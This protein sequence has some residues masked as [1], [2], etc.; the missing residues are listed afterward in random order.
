MKERDEMVNLTDALDD[1]LARVAAGESL[2]SSLARYTSCGMAVELTALVQARA[3]LSALDPAP[4]LPT[5]ALAA[6]RRQFFASARAHKRHPTS[7]NPLQ[8]LAV[9]LW[10][11]RPA[12]RPA[13]MT[14]LASA[15]MAFVLV[16]GIAGG[17]LTAAQSSLPDSPLY[18][19]KLAVEDARL[20]L[21]GDPS[22]QAMLSLSF[23]SERAREMERLAV[24]NRP[25]ENRVSQR[26]DNQLE[27]ALDAASRAPEHEM[28][29]LLDKV[30]AM[31]QAQERALAQAR[32]N[33]PREARSQDALREAEQAMAQARRQAHAGLADPGAF[34]NRTRHEQGAP[35]PP[36]P[37]A[38]ATPQPPTPTPAAQLTATTEATG[39]PQ[40]SRTPQASVTPQRNQV[41]TGQ[42]TS[43]PGPQA[44]VTP[45]QIGPGPQPTAGSTGPGPQPTDRPGDGPGGGDGSG[46]GSGGGTGGTRRP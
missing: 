34:R 11:M 45:Q 32:A 29:R 3:H 38:T 26:L 10:P 27:N 33:A 12:G 15:A 23:A 8:R 40:P 16:L 30:Q 14:G 25:I 37:E 21:A 18:G 19:I 31:A 46:P 20:N 1:V 39:T 6:R 13:L 17:T 44:T 9:W 24:A 2:E 5:D 36:S 28:L 22:Q 42:P 4:A 7:A 35:V 43:A 41:A